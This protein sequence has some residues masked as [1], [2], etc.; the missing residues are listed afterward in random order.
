MSEKPLVLVTGITGFLGSHVA[1]QLLAAGYKV[2]GTLR[3]KAKGEKVYDAVLPA[4]VDKS[5]LELFEIDLLDPVSKWE[6]AVKGCTY[7]QHIAS[8]FQIE[9]ANVDEQFF[10]KPAVEGTLNV[11]KATLT[12][13]LVKRVVLTSS[14]VAVSGGRE[15]E[16]DVYSNGKKVQDGHAF[17]ENDWTNVDK[18]KGY[19]KSK[20]LAEKAA[21]NF[22]EENKKPFELATVNPSYIMGPYLLPNVGAS[23]YF[24]KALLN[25]EYPALPGYMYMQYVDVRDVALCHVRAMEVPEAAGHRHIANAGTGS[26][27]AYAQLIHKEFAPQGYNPPTAN[28]PYFVLRLASWFDSNMVTA[29]RLYN[30][31]ITYDTSGT[32]SRLGVKWRPID[33]S[34][35]ALTYSMIECGYIKKTPGFKPRKDLGTLRSRAKGANVFDKVVPFAVDQSNLVLFEIEF[36]DP[37]TK[38]ETA[39]R[40]CPYIHHIAPPFLI[41][42]A[43]ETDDFFIKPAVEGTLNVLK[44]CL[45]EPLLKRV[46][47]TSSTVAMT[48]GREGEF[49]IYSR[50]K[51]LNQT[52][53]SDLKDKT[54]NGNEKSKTLAEQA[55][56]KFIEDNN[57]PF[58]LA[59]VNPALIFGPY[60]LPNVGSGGY[61]TRFY[62]IESIPRFL[63]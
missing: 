32:E 20:T 28:I 37:P 33:T 38:W 44:A 34:I 43:G 19:Q 18:V 12:E 14:T 5:K 27:S 1:N 3:S 60:L 39:I 9:N 55:A 16:Y 63:G 21:W 40:G 6:S 53:L 4:G 31:D 59:T 15:S 54:V 35:L 50:G 61:F 8:P 29:A 36:L 52:D 7:I 30:K 46:V 57:N 10:I 26:I 13:P 22:I 17:N 23:G 58:E 56:W 48:S 45:S 11:L 62:S 51:K 49:D 41:D 2:R 47:L 42:T 25:R 24:S